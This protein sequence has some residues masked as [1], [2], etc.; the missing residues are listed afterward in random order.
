MPGLN[1]W[2]R[3]P[4]HLAQLEMVQFS[5]VML[6]PWAATIAAALAGAG[7]LRL[8]ARPRVGGVI[9]PRPLVGLRQLVVAVGAQWGAVVAGR[10]GAARIGDLFGGQRAVRTP[11][12]PCGW[13]RDNPYWSGL[14]L[15]RDRSNAR[16]RARARR[17]ARSAAS[18]ARR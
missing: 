17:A 10:P 16:C 15:R 6:L 9:G 2:I 4:H 13:R 18:A 12:S 5:T 1:I 3:L 7:L 11:G 8:T 14:L